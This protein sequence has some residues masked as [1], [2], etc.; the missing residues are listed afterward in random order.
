VNWFA[1]FGKWFWAICI[2]VAFLNARTFQSRAHPHIQAHPELEEG[3]RTLTKGFLFWGN[4]PWVVMGIGC[5]FGGVPSVFDFFHPRDGNPFVLAFYFSVLLVWILGTNW[6]LFR[7]GAEML[8]KHP[9]ILNV[10]FKSPRTIVLFW[11]LCLAG[12]IV[13]VIMLFFGSMPLPPH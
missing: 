13:A 11:F 1:T 5:I 3:Y 9:G 2:F 6:L 8:V 12:G 10:D 4:L 7:G